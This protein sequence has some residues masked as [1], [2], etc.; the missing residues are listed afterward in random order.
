MRSFI[1]FPTYPKLSFARRRALTAVLFESM[2]L[3][4]EGLDP[5]KVLRLFR[6][7]R[8]C[9]LCLA[10]TRLF[11]DGGAGD[12]PPIT[13]LEDPFKLILNQFI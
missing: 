2:P 7:F 11:L 5:V 4:N 1:V 8:D 10:S 12:I 3:E 13:F 9:C 6:I